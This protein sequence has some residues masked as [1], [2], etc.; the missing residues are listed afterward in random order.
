MPWA[1]L[2]GLM[3]IAPDA[4][5]PLGEHLVWLPMTGATD[6]QMAEAAKA[7]FDTVLWKIRP[8]PVPDHSGVDFKLL[9]ERLALARRYGLKSMVAILG[10]AGLGTGAY[11]DIDEDGKKLPNQLDPFWPEAMARLEWAYGQIIDRYHR[12]PDVIAFVPTWGIY[13]EAGFISFAA[14]RSDHALAR[15]NEWRKRQGWSPVEAIPTCREGPNTECNRFIRFRYVYMEEQFDGI[16]RRLK[17]RAGGKPVGTWQELYPVVGYLWTMVA[18]PTADFALYES[19][20]PFQTSHRPESTLAET[21]GFRYRCD[22]ADSYR[23]YYLPLLA[24]K[25]GEGQRFMGCQLSNDYAVKNYGWSPEKAAAVGFDAWEDRFAPYL[26]R[27]HDAPLEVVQRDVLLVFPTYAAAA[28]SEGPAHAVDAMTIDVLLRMFGCQL[29]RCGSPALDKM[30]VAELDRYRLIIVPCAAYLLSETLGRL[31]QCSATV[32]LTGSFGRSLDAELVPE[33][34]Q[35]T[36]DGVR[37]RYLRRPAGEMRVVAEHTLTHGLGEEGVVLPEDETFEYVEAPVMVRPWLAC[38]DRT[39]LSTAD[40]GRL[41]Y[42]HGHV[43]AGLSYDPQRTPPDRGGS[44]DASA[45]EVDMWGPY[46]ST[47]PS[48]RVGQ[49]LMRNILDHAGVEY[50]VPDPKPRIA[51]RYLGDHMEQASISGNLAYNNTDVPQAL[52]VRLPYRPRG[53]PCRPRGDRFEA[54]ITVPPFGYVVLEPD[55]ASE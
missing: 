55:G 8:T 29:R 40:N 16:M 11:F 27:L 9:D 28:L 22:S 20:F 39:L 41:V 42:V 30:T 5:W 33:G 24:R 7:G 54:P 45:N 46:S 32:L 51:T 3:L 2:A 10:E 43:F 23:D 4:S 18:V 47:H 6:E 49:R 15:F 1:L 52:L 37:V 21:M 34:G 14:G 25:R 31:K 38:G 36:I 19:C 26:K 53:W 13:G 50:R 17:T 12:D 44:A 35:R 48:N